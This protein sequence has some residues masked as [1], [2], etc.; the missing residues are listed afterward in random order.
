MPGIERQATPASSH[1]ATIFRI[2]L[3][4]AVGMARFDFPFDTVRAAVVRGISE[5]IL[6]TNGV[7]PPR[8]TGSA[9][10]Q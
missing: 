2:T 5:A 3:P 9:N 6:W 1:S 7:T 8:R 10:H 4:G